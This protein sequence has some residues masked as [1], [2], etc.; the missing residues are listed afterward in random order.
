M[1]KVDGGDV[2]NLFIEGS[3]SQFVL[4]SQSQAWYSS[5]QVISSKV[6]VEN[7][8]IRATAS[9]RRGQ[10]LETHVCPEKSGQC[11]HAHQSA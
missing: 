2:G 8:V 6:F 5:P 3:W 7:T 10:I 11:V 1:V 4:Q 9:Q